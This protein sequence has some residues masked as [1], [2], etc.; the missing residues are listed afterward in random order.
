M[1]QRAELPPAAD[2]LAERHYREALVSEEQAL[3]IRKKVLGERHHATAESPNNVA[4][5]DEKLQANAKAKPLYQQALEIRRKVVGELHPDTIQSLENLASLYVKEGNLDAAERLYRQALANRQR[6]AG[7]K[8]PGAAATFQQL[9][10]IYRHEDPAARRI[11]PTMRRP[12][13]RK[14]ESILACSRVAT[15][16]RIAE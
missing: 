15:A 5:L 3:E 13:K 9:M 14:I 12:G 10:R 8:D 4:V 6:L 1:N 2:R 16:S 7:D 11:R